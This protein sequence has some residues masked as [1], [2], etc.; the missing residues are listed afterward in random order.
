MSASNLFASLS[1][2]AYF[3][4]MQLRGPKLNGCKASRLSCAYFGL[5]SNQR[6]GRNFSGSAKLVGER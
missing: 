6:S 2:N 4:P 1:E 3:L 5:P